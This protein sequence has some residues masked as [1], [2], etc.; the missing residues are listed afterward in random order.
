MKGKELESGWHFWHAWTFPRSK[1]KAETE[2]AAAPLGG[3]EAEI[4]AV[5]EDLSFPRGRSGTL[6]EK[7]R[8]E[9]R[10]AERQHQLQ[11]GL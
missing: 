3:G 5:A 11:G 2:A 10:E 6:A 1:E 9:R 8:R 4:L 7:W